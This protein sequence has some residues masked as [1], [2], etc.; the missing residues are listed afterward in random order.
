MI[1]YI[2]LATF[3]GSL[4][5]GVAGWLESGE[6]F[7]CRKFIATA[8]RGFVASIITAITLNFVEA[9]PL[10]YLLAFLSGA[11]IDV[12]GKRVSGAIKYQNINNSKQGDSNG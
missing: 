1:I 2:V 8:I 4:A 11:G 7:E 9:S 6:K 10:N 5:A 12:L 3:A